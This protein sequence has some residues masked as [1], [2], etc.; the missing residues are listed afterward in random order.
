MVT[1]LMGPYKISPKSALFLRAAEIRAGHKG[2]SVKR[3][4]FWLKKN[5]I[6]VILKI[7]MSSKWHE[8]SY[9]THPHYQNQFYFFL[10]F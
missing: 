6:G 2:A 10:F 8:I 9:L 3:A 4:I 5:K 1:Y 7:Y